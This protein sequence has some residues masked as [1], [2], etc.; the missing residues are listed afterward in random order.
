MA[1]YRS[2]PPPPLDQPGSPPLGAGLEQ[3]PSQ[4]IARVTR[5]REVSSGDDQGV[6]A[7]NELNTRI[8]ICPLAYVRDHFGQGRLET[9]L[10]DAGGDPKLFEP[11]F[12]WVSHALF[13]RVLDGVRQQLRS[14]QEFMLA[15][16]Y[17]LREAYGPL[18]LVLRMASIKRGYRMFASTSQ[19]VSKISRFEVIDLGRGQVRIRYTSTKPESRLM[20]LSRIAQNQAGPTLW[21]GVPP[22]VVIEE[23]CISRGD[24]ECSYTLRWKEPVRWPLA[25]TGALASAAL[26]L[27]PVLALHWSAGLLP[28]M[29]VAG[30]LTGWLLEA[31]R[32][33]AENERVVLDTKDALLELA[34]SHQEATRE[35]IDLHRRQQLWNQELETLVAERTATL[36]NVV[37]KLRK[38]GQ[39]QSRRVQSLSHDIRNPLTIIKYSADFVR[40]SVPE[41]NIT[42]DLEGILADLDDAADR[43]ERL[44]ND[45]ARTA[46]VEPVPGAS[47]YDAVEVGVLAKS[48]RRRL[49]ALVLGREVRTT[50]FQ[51]RECPTELRADAILL[52]R[53]LDNLLTNAAKYTDRGGIL[54]EFDGVPGFLCMRVSDTGRGISA[55]RLE[56]VFSG[57]EPDSSP[58]VGTSL[59]L[60]LSVV[61]RTL[62][63]LSGRLEVMSRPGQG[64][65]FWLYIPVE[66]PPDGAERKARPEDEPLDDM[67]RRIIRI[68]EVK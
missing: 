42:P 15:C 67:V 8:L 6:N 48:V 45:L 38:L 28:L 3:R 59:G 63:Q 29:G 18:V 30:L 20:C 27:V 5:L 33:V 13:E 66:P 51:S 56:A 40:Q 50:V 57:V 61:V 35:L 64:T 16:A 2:A 43:T 25:A 24:P 39:V 49:N 44:L 11:P 52:D 65:T 68:R 62:A 34:V 22:P 26:G 12:G 1:I 14:D 9:V 37:G 17:K 46:T 4:G 21:W 23:S 31:R 36:E 10:R 47:R 32:L 60:G 58:N 41:K 54:V 7:D 55:D 53:V 19:V